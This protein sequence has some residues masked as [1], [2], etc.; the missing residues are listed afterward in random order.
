MRLKNSDK[1]LT[2]SDERWMVKAFGQG[3]VMQAPACIQ[4]RGCGV[5]SGMGCSCTQKHGI[6]SATKGAP[7]I[8]VS[9]LN[10]F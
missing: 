8:E 5:E 4:R 3:L 10:T 1:G 6:T 9:R 7:V 2:T